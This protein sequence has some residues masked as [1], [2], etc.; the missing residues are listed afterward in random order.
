MNDCEDI[1]KSNVAHTKASPI[2]NFLD[3]DMSRS[4][5]IS[6]VFLYFCPLAWIVVPEHVSCLQL[7][8][9]DKYIVCG[10]RTVMA[11]GLW[12]LLT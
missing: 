7:N 9:H 8:R 2:L 3:T 6:N 4:W 10:E 11:T 5:I 1:S 12:F